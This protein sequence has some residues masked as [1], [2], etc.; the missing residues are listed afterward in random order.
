MKVLNYGS[1]NVDYVYSLDHI[2]QGG[3]TILSSKME[4]FCGGKGLNQSI[5]LA[6]AG[7]PVYHAGLVGEE[8]SILLDKG[9]HTIIQVDAKGQN[10]IILYGGTNQMQ[11]KEYIDEVLSNFG[12]DDFL[13]LQNEVNLLDYIIDRGHDRGMKI[14]L[15]PSP[16]D[17]KLMAC[18]LSKVYLFLLN[19]IE[20]E[21]FTGFSDVDQI[22]TALAG[23]F[24][25]ARFVLTLGSEGALYYDGKEKIFQD[26]FP[27]KA[28]DTTAAGDT[29]TGFFIAAL[30]E[31]TSIKEALRF[32]ARASAI[33]VSRP[34]A[35][36]SIPCIEEVKRALSLPK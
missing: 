29:F 22:L 1:L 27:V 5:A 16:F 15:N 20:G 26:I 14:V 24:P 7:V 2:V 28:V 32:A 6:R 35:A 4:V 9:G 13:I 11:T 17:E 10:C 33:A 21:Q 12:K 8:G 23:K 34:G 19:E 3:E 30:L 36:P 18:D 25:E 31:G